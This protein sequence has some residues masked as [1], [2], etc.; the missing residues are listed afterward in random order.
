MFM[1]IKLYKTRLYNLVLVNPSQSWIYLLTCYT[2]TYTG[3]VAYVVACRSQKWST[4]LK[5]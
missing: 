1:K 4:Q 3:Q 5:V 2:L